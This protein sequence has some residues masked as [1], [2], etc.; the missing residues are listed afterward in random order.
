MRVSACWGF[1]VV[2]VALGEGVG[3]VTLRVHP[4]GVVA[5][6]EVVELVTLRAVMS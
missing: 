2:V 3:W 1:P 6:G 4:V 5:L